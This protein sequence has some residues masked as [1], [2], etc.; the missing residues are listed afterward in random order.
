LAAP[1][2]DAVM[3]LRYAG[4]LS[5]G[6]HAAEES[7]VKRFNLYCAVIREADGARKVVFSL[8]ERGGGSWPWPERFGAIDFDADL[9]PVSPGGIRLLY[10]YEGNPLVIPLPAAIPVPRAELKAGGKWTSGKENWE[11]RGTMK[12]RGRDCW[13]VHVSTPIGH[14]RTL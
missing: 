12:V 5:K 3:E 2:D 9:K 14:V 1:A 10:E 4:S 6:A 13:Q 11:V 7:P 8:S